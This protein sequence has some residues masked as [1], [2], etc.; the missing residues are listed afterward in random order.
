MRGMV[1]DSMA[2][3]RAFMVSTAK[4]TPSGR[5][6]NCLITMVKRPHPIPKISW[7]RGVTGE[8][9]ISVAMKTAANSSPPAVM[10][11]QGSKPQS[12]ARIKALPT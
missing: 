7:P 5:E 9:T 12:S 3:A 10:V 2:G 8:V 6:V 11:Y 1:K 4:V